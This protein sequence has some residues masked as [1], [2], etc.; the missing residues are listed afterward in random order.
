MSFKGSAN[1]GPIPDDFNFGGVDPNA[2]SA[3]S[4]LRRNCCV[5]VRVN[6]DL[7]TAMQTYSEELN[8]KTMRQ[9]MEG[10]SA[11]VAAD[12]LEAGL[13]MFTGCGVDKNVQNA[14]TWWYGI[15]GKPK[16]GATIS[17]KIRVRAL[18]CLAN[19]QWDSRMTEEEGPTV[20]NIDAA[21]RAAMHANDCA[22]LGFVSPAV[23]VIGMTIKQ[24]MEENKF[25]QFN[26]PRFHEL[27]FLW[28]AVER[29]EEEMK[30]S[31]EKR[32]EKVAKA[33]NAYVCAAEGC[34]IEGTR[35]SGLLRKECQKADWKR[36]KSICKISE[37]PSAT[38]EDASSSSQTVAPAIV[39]P[40]PVADDALHLRD[41]GREV[42]MEI[43]RLGGGTTTISSRTMSPGFMK[44]F[45]DQIEKMVQEEEVE[46]D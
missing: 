25:Q 31:T 12:C 18:S 39:A 14:M 30:K 27:E 46:T 24:L 17:K 23:L 4:S 11:G 21:H 41:D 26:N 38:N 10:A 8:S 16:T 5:A 15:A 28:E 33:P 32:N 19:A 34:G 3:Y 42:R 6:L 44:E 35:K 13:R 43:P 1:V 36:H 45:R 40:T 29:R 37:A 9:V 22:S 7:F 20:W 2:F